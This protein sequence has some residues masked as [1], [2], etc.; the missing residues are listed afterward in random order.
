MVLDGPTFVATEGWDW[1]P[2]I[3]DRNTGLWQ[4]VTLTATARLSIG[5]PQVITTL[6]LPDNS[7]ADVEIDVPIT[8]VSGAPVQ[9][10]VVASF[11]GNT[12]T[13]HATMPA[14]ESTVKFTSAEFAALTVQHPR[15]WWPNNYGK[16]ELYRLKL[17]VRA[18]D[19]DSD[20]RELDFG[21]R[22][23]TY[24]LSLYDSTGHLR[25]VEIAP[26]RQRNEQIV[27]V[28]HA[29]MRQIPHGWAATL[30]PGSES[31]PAVKK[32]ADEMG[33]TDLILRVNGVRIAARGGNWG[34]D[35]SRKRVSVEHLEPYFRLHRDAHLNI[36]RN[37]VGQ[38]TEESFY[39]LADKYGILVWNDFWASTEDYNLEP[40]DPQL[41]LKNARDTILRFRNHP[42]IVVWCGRNEGV[43]QPI[44]NEGLESLIQ[45]LD[46]TRYYSPSSN[47]VNLRDSGPYDYKEPAT[48]YKIN[49][50]FSV[51]L[52]VPSF[53]TLES[54]QAWIPKQDQWPI[55]DSWAYHD[56]HQSGNGRADPFMHQIE[57]EFGAATSLEDFDRKAQMLD[58]EEHRAIFEGFNAHLWTPN[59]GRLLWMTQPAWPSN[60]W[61]ILS[62]DYDTQSSFYGVMKA[63]E[64]VHVQLDLTNGD[65]QVVNTTTN[66]ANG[67]TLSASVY[68]LQGELLLDHKQPID[69]GANAMTPGFPLAIAPLMAD[70]VVLIKLILSQ[71]DGKPVS[72]NFYWLAEN[73]ASYRELN[74]LPQASLR[75]T[76]ESA[77]GR[78]EGRVH[79]RIE[80]LGTSPALAIKL[81]LEKAND[82]TRVLPAYLTDN[83]ISLLPKEARDI[84]ISYPAQAASGE[85][86]LAV[87][88][89]NF[90]STSIAVAKR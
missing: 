38:N 88:G 76:S 77:E 21:I 53:S 2:A 61:Q 3:R 27:D 9:G 8:N 50:G 7:R 75:I 37:W 25:R 67:L 65:V 17:A 34:M 73:A 89:W 35:D 78:E 32:L 43:P 40:E 16:P 85:M 51:E 64:P 45:S 1:I 6:P 52:G 23:I 29:G 68:S 70:H 82:S 12:F 36:I 59:S 55:S 58:Y 26:A 33:M 69:A 79:V 20:V 13:K 15:L 63:C 81:I 19:G 48:Y 44:I 71:A 87:R 56:W 72:D 4:D 18:G 42:S 31:S 54:F 86:K 5:D 46:G 62:S 74:T 22:E 49:R 10:T 28:S 80:N 41:F 60:M 30:M 24:E 57:K 47:R 66:P 90:A 14:G 11:D 39:Q 83:Y 84:D